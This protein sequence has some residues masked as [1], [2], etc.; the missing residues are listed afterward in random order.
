MA[1]ELV[2][3]LAT[4]TYERIDFVQVETWNRIRKPHHHDNQLAKPF[5]YVDHTDQITA[6]ALFV[7]MLSLVKFTH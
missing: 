7:V 6:I 1:Y 5:D 2:H 3:D 4:D